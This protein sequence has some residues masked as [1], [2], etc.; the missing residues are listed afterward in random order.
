MTTLFG[1]TTI[2]RVAPIDV[3]V[4]RKKRGWM[5]VLTILFCISYSLM[6]MLIIEQ[7]STI[8]SQRALIRELF[9]DSS[10]LSASKMKAL[11]EKHAAQTPPAQA[12]TQAPSTQDNQAPSSQAAQQHARQNPAPRMK[13][14]Y[15]MPSRPA[16]D[17]ADSRRVLITI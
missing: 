15:Q 1:D 2:T 16:S 4:P 8:E 7:G 12:Q 10:E 11:Q 17:L 3:P 5:P 6:T 9:R 13:P 14:Q